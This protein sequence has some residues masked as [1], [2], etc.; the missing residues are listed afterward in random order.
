MRAAFPSARI[1]EV[2]TGWEERWRDFHRPARVGPLW[3]GPPWENV[4]A[5][6]L[7]VVI[8]PGRAFGTGAH[9]TTRLCLELL[10]EVPHGSVLDV[11]CGSGVLAIAAARLGFGPVVAVDVDEAAID[12][13]RTNATTNGV[14]IDVH[15]LDALEGGLP[16]ADIVLANLT[17]ESVEALAPL[18]DATNLVTSGYLDRDLPQLEGWTRVARRESDGWAGELFTRGD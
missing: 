2:E 3:I 13:A 4:P 17:L 8:D 16:V 9:A 12:A 1:S 6:A 18:V 10:L 5:E 11:G 7:A 15:R 14:A